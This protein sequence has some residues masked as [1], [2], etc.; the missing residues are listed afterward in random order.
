MKNLYNYWF[1]AACQYY[2]MAATSHCF[3]CIFIVEILRADN[4]A[5][6]MRYD[7]TAGWFVCKGTTVPCLA[8]NPWLKTRERA[9]LRICAM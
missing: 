6:F 7:V 1:I 4:T 5:N 2:L 9:R 8:S 3:K